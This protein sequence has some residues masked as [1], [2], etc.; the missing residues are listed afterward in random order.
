MEEEEGGP[1]PPK[2]VVEGT[3][4]FLLLRLFLYRLVQSAR[5]SLK[6]DFVGVPP[7]RKA[8]FLV[9]TGSSPDLRRKFPLS[10]SPK[11]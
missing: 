3:E 5:A 9:A 11:L 4:F 10:V 6:G 2:K 7:E 8:G 1:S